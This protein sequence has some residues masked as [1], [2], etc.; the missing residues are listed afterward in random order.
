MVVRVLE[1]LGL[2]AIVLGV[3]A[4]SFLP[5]S[6]PASAIVGGVLMMGYAEYWDRAKVRR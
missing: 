4:L 6:L 5:H 2:V 1:V 3:A